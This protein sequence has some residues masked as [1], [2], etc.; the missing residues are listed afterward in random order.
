MKAFKKLIPVFD[1]SGRLISFESPIKKTAWDGFKLS[2]DKVPSADNKHGIYAVFDPEDNQL[3]EYDRV[4]VELDAYGIVV[5]GDRGLRAE[6]ARIIS[7]DGTGIAYYYGRR[8]GPS[9]AARAAAC[10][11][12]L[13]AY[14]YAYGVDAAPRDDTRAAACESPKYA[15]LYA[16]YVDRAPHDDTRAAACMEAETAYWYALEV[17]RC[18]RDD[19]RAAA[20]RNAFL[21]YRYALFE[22]GDRK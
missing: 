13:W 9:D 14:E 2:A 16:L 11:S 4:L 19:T 20:C 17:D 6:H 10:E 3:D 5:I 7:W 15:Y 12:P 8:F 1:E 21:A 22:K 18:A